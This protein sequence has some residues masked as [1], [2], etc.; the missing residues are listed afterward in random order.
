MTNKFVKLAIKQIEP[1]SKVAQLRLLMPDIEVKLGEGVQLSAVHK[2]LVAAGFDLSFQTFKTYLYRIRRK[3]KTA[4]SFHNPIANT[5]ALSD[6]SP[7]SAT[8]G[9]DGTWPG[10][11][12]FREH[13][14]TMEIDRL[15]KPDPAQQAQKIARYERLAKHQRRNKE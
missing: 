10:A 12:A 6:D 13:I 8:V 9:M 11:S 3:E 1:T 4:Q 5:E 2:V 15:M 7:K 14:S